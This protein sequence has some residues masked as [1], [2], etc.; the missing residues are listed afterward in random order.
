MGKG[1]DSM[2]AAGPSSSGDGPS[3][4]TSAPKPVLDDPQFAPFLQAE[5]D[6]AQFTSR[7]LA[8]SHTTAQAQSE[9]LREG[10]RVL[11]AELREEVTGRS[12]ELLDHVKRMS[13]AETSLQEVILG[14]GSLQAAVKRIRGEIVGPYDA[15]KTKTRQLHN[16]HATID[17]LRLIVHRIKLTQKLKAQL[18]AAPGSLDLAKAAKLITDIRSVDAEADLSGLDAVAAD[19]A[20]VTEATRTVRQQAQVR[21]GGGKHAC[22]MRMVD[23]HA[24]NAHASCLSQWHAFPA[25]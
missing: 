21:G 16:L 24:M 9:Q 7:V 13:G 17:L 18:A 20:F 19:E 2:D 11:D 5:F 25:S 8:G 12:A 23:Q 22:P 6:V 1:G 3:S 15:V 4:T 14:V 10:V